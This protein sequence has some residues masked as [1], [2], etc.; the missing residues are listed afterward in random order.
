MGQRE[1][2]TLSWLRSKRTLLDS[3]NRANFECLLCAQSV[4]IIPS[5][6]CFASVFGK[7]CL[8][9]IFIVSRSPAIR[10]AFCPSSPSLFCSCSVLQCLRSPVMFPLLMDRKEYDVARISLNHV[11]V[12]TIDFCTSR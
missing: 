7:L 2:L 3:S 12:D 9:P 11:N 1:S 10:V 4:F 8:F 5:D 6:S